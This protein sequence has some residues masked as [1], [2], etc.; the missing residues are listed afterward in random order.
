MVLCDADMN[1]QFIDI[2]CEHIDGSLPVVLIRVKQTPRNK[3]IRFTQEQSVVLDE[4]LRVLVRQGT[5]DPASSSGTRLN[6]A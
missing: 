2:L 3:T 6:E 1:N 5:W 4:L